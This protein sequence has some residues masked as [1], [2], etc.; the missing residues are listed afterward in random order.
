MPPSMNDGATWLAREFNTRKAKNASFS[1]RAFAR[2]LQ[3][4]PAQ[5]SQLIS[6]KRPFSKKMAQSLSGRLDLTPLERRRFLQACL[7]TGP[8][9][10]PSQ[11]VPTRYLDLEEDRFKLI[12]EWY[13]FAILSLTRTPGARP[14]PRWIGRRLGIVSTLASQALSR[15]ERLGLIELKPVFRQ[16]GDPIRVLPR[17]ASLAVRK[18]HRQNLQL[19]AEKLEQVPKDKRIFHSLTVALD[20]RR[21]PELQSLIQRTMNEASESFEGGRPSEVYTLALQLFPVTLNLNPKALAPNTRSLSKEK[22]V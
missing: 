7:G 16:V 19:A 1:L 8:E 3:I 18:Y 15:L 14:D 21:L 20:P 11:K 9:P 12:S 13:H 5:A 4:S 2:W 17:E 10:L 22:M 6:G